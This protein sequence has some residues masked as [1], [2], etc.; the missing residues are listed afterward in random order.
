MNRF[1][2][3]T[4]LV[5]AALTLAGPVL[6]QDATGDQTSSRA[7]LEQALASVNEGGR[8]YQALPTA[9]Q[10][11]FGRGFFVETER[12]GASFGAERVGGRETVSETRPRG[13]TLLQR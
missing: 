5:V 7:A 2:A 8:D 11:F 10:G 4:G 13:V 6:A 9:G 3:K 1:I 12:A